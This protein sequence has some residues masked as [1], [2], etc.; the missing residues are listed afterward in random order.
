MPRPYY[1]RGGLSGSAS[2]VRL[3]T[4][5]GAGYVSKKGP[6]AQMTFGSL[7]KPKS[8]VSR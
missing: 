2:V 7:D 6:L 5:Y 4:I 3:G 1:G 8:L